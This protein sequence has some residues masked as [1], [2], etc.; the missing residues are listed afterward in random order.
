MEHLWGI[1]LGGTKIE[2]AIL[3][4][5]ALNRPLFR[6]RVP[7]ESEQ[8]YEHIRKQ[9][10][11]LLKTLAAESG[12]PLPPKIGMGTPGVVDPHTGIVDPERVRR[13]GRAP[14]INLGILD[15]DGDAGLIGRGF[16]SPPLSLFC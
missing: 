5:S 16:Y 10:G 6:V 14:L 13:A 12:L 7:T 8:G 9:I 3:D 1:D 11:R 4:S 2:G 15:R